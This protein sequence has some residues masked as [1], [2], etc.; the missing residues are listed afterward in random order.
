MFL[1]PPS[2]G[3]HPPGN[4]GPPG[5]AGVPL[6]EG[7]RP[8]DPAALLYICSSNLLVPAGGRG[9]SSP[10][11]T[12]PVW[13]IAAGFAAPARPRLDLLGDV[14]LLC[15]CRSAG[16]RW[17]QA[18]RAVQRNDLQQVR[19]LQDTPPRRRCSL[20]VSVTSCLRHFLSPS[21]T[22]APPGGGPV[23]H[24]LTLS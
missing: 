12:C 24:Q 10:S 19:L 15:P 7:R 13:T 8:N 22:S 2:G 9:G 18:E 17:H 23:L 16:P 3:S 11:L 21:R 14:T 4:Q 20:P 5:G 6:T 1:A